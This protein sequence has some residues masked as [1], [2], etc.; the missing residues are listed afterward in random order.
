MIM[1]YIGTDSDGDNLYNVNFAVGVKAPSK[2]DDVFLVQW[3]LY[4]VYTDSPFFQPPDAAGI[5]IDGWIGKQTIKWITAFQKVVRK[6]GNRCCVD[7]RVD[8]A[9]KSEGSISKAPY[10]ILWLNSFFRGS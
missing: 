3:M 1:A 7:G 8:S 2:R 5:S 4:R 9:R 6:L 10:T